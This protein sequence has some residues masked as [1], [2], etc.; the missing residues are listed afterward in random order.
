MKSIAAS[1]CLL[2]ALAAPPAEAPK[3]TA[4][5]APAHPRTDA[6]KK[7]APEVHITADTLDAL[8]GQK[9]VIYRGNVLAVRE[10]MRVN[11]NSLT[12]D[13][14]E[15]KKLKRLTCTGNVHMHQ[16]ASPPQHEEREAWGD[17]AVFENDSGVLT[18]TGSPH[19]RDGANRMKGEKVLFDTNTDHLRAEGSK[20]HPVETWIE[21]PPDKGPFAPKPVKKEEPKK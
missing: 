10:D 9:Q 15:Q 14:D 1:V 11:C 5:K 8:P 19:G 17:L 20:G 7:A 2:V 6:A 16:A 3:T 18:V 13:Y 4:A 12:A 21:T